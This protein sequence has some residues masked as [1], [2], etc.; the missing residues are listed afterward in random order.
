MLALLILFSSIIT[1]HTIS[2]D[3]MVRAETR[4]EYLCEVG[5]WSHEGLEEVSYGLT[6]ILGENL[7]RG[8]KGDA[9]KTFVAWIN[10]P[11]HWDNITSPI[12]TQTGIGYSQ[13]CDIVVQ[14]FN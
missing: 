13:E 8:Y 7:A 14:L 2:A 10:S 9:V 3:L 6:G 5:Q 12:F 11:T 1:P 4:A